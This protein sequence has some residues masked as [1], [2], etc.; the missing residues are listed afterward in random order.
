MLLNSVAREVNLL[1]VDWES[2]MRLGNV[3]AEQ[4]TLWRLSAAASIS[5]SRD[6]VDILQL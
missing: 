4:S 3:M 2:G 6:A 1:V 5:D